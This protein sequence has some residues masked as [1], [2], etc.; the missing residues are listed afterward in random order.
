MEMTSPSGRTRQDSRN[1]NWR[2][3]ILYFAAAAWRRDFNQDSPGRAMDWM[4]WISCRSSCCRSGEF[5]TIRTTVMVSQVSQTVDVTVDKRRQASSHCDTNKTERKSARE[6]WPGCAVDKMADTVFLLVM[7]YQEIVL[8]IPWLRTKPIWHPTPLTPNYFWF[9]LHRCE[10]E[11]LKAKSRRRNRRGLKERTRKVYWTGL[12]IS[13]TAD[14]ELRFVT[15]DPWPSP[16]PWHESITT[17][18]TLWWVH[19]YCLFFLQWCAI[20]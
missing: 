6:S 14:N 16:R 15:R 20:I 5:D 11:R 2:A 18:H 4:D 12:S 7:L 13:N 17:T 9:L 3:K 1:D 10:R 8:I 19:D